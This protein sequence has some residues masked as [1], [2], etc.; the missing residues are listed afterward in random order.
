MIREQ[1]L[2]IA[3]HEEAA[4]AAGIHP[5]TFQRWLE[6]G[7]RDFAADKTSDFRD[8]YD[9]VTAANRAIKTVLR[10][11]VIAA[12]R[13]DPKLALKILERRWPQEWGLKIEVKDASAKPKASPR[14]SI[15][16]KLAQIEE[17][18]SAATRELAGMID[19]V[20]DLASGE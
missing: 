16:K 4:H 20:K 6:H 11:R 2:N 14:D 17:R 13:T 8:F 10:G 7:A 12:S 18:Q 5:S 1:L 19:S 9:L 3:T 15:M